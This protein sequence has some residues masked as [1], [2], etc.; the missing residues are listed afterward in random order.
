MNIEDKGMAQQGNPLSSFSRGDCIRL[1]SDGA[2][3]E[4]CIGNLYLVGAIP[5]CGESIATNLRDGCFRHD[6]LFVLEPSA[7]VV[8]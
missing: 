1:V 4:Q 8:I 3:C 2:P 5:A 7:T 6:G